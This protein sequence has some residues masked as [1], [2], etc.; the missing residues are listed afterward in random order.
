MTD[1]SK[2]H[3]KK[4]APALTPEEQAK[5]LADKAAAEA[6]AKAERERIELYGKALPNL[7]HR[8]LRSELVKTVKRE[9]AGRPPQPQAGLTIAFATV[10]LA[11]LDNTRTAEKKLRPDQ[12]NP[13][14]KLHT[15]P[16]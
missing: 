9:Y 15:Y 1:K 7:S 8:Q 6:A 10:L 11:V 4:K 14:G 5:F 2:R 16:L 13:K 3:L 12:I